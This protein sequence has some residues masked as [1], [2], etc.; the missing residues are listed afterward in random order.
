MPIINIFSFV[1]DVRLEVLSNCWNAN[2][3]ASIN[4]NG[5]H[6]WNVMM[7]LGV[8]TS[9]RQQS[10]RGANFYLSNI[11]HTICVTWDKELSCYHPSHL[12][13]LGKMGSPNSIV[14]E[15]VLIFTFWKIFFA[16]WADA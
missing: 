6:P 2:S 8:R 4:G 12:L 9:V 10:P 5:L 14:A 11:T 3:S 15:D 13:P 16:I 1:I 7:S